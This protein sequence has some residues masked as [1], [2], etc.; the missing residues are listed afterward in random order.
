M[1]TGAVVVLVGFTRNTFS[2]P[3][4]N[5]IPVELS[6][7]IQSTETEPSMMSQRFTIL[8]HTTAGSASP[9]MYSPLTGRIL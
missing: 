5:S 1:F 8:F 6:T 4:G 3:E 2:T 7:H 9:G